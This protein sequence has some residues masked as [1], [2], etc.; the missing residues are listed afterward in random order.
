MDK[1][2][3]NAK[4]T[5]PAA[6]RC[7]P[8]PLLVSAEIWELIFRISVY[9]QYSKAQT[10]TMISDQQLIDAVRAGDQAG[11]DELFQRYHRRLFGLLWH[12]CGNRD[13][14]EDLG[15]EAFFRAY[16]KLHLYSG[17]AQFYTW[18]AKIAMNLLISYHR[19]RRIENQ[20]AREGFDAAADSLQ[21]DNPP[22]SKLESNETQQCVQQAIAML[23][24]DRR[25]VLLLRDFEE[26]DYEAIAHVL[27]LPIGTVRS[28]L[29]RARSDL[30]ILIQS[31]AAQLGIAELT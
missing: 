1:F 21:A 10:N 22:E 8:D 2:G 15:Q 6:A 18:L 3:Y 9:F 27:D 11:F 24:E 19:K 14:A 12:A 31:K 4:N 20:L 7:L 28:R 17:H 13:L 29:H 16:R 23:D 25:I 26:M 5:V 30:K